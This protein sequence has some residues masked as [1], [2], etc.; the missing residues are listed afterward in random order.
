MALQF[1]LPG[2]AM[3]A[4]FGLM[5]QLFQGG[6]G[7]GMSG[8]VDN[9]FGGPQQSGN[10]ATIGGAITGGAFGLFSGGIPGALVG[11][12]GGGLVGRLLDKLFNKGQ[13]K[14]CQRHGQQCQNFPPP[15]SQ[16]GWGGAGNGCYGGG[17]PPYQQGGG[18]GQQPNWGGQQQWGGQGQYQQGYQDGYNAGIGNQTQG[19]WPPRNCWQPQPRQDIQGN[20]TCGVNNGQL[21][22][23]GGE[24]KPIGYTTR[25]GWNVS[26]DGHKIVMTDPSGQ[27]K[28]EHSGDPHEYLNGKHVKD[29]Q[30]KDRTV[31][32]PDGTKITM[33]ADSP[34]GLV[35]GL[36]I[37]DGDRNIQV[38]NLANKITSQSNNGYETRAKEAWQA[39]GET[40][41]VSY[42]RD[43]IN[44]SNLY[45]QDKNLG[46]TS[47]FKDIGTMPYK[48]DFNYAQV[49]HQPRFQF[50]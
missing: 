21:I 47:A 16:G 43:G 39:D 40:A 42:G 2:L 32:L 36:S 25:G 45:N 26:I 19:N 20:N 13:N 11:A 18:W 33:N 5:N 48:K 31:I 17:I 28:I 41:M 37:Y 4:G 38:D 1:M 8:A 23:E 50:A 46:F 49:N 3:G 10:G 9:I 29:W 34:Q 22:Q 30:G 14:N 12:L 7:Q 6:Q 27:H 35:K 24:G 44:Y 15:G